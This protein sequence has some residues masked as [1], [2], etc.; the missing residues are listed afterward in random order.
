MTEHVLLSVINSAR[1]PSG[2]RADS[3]SRARARA[4]DPIPYPSGTQKP[5][6]VQVVPQAYMRHDRL[7]SK[8]LE[9]R[10]SASSEKPKRK[11]NTQ[12]RPGPPVFYL[13]DPEMYVDPSARRRVLRRS[14]LR[15]EHCGAEHE[16]RVWKDL[17]DRYTWW[18]VIP[19]V[20]APRRNLN[21]VDVRIVVV[22]ITVPWNGDDATLVALCRGCWIWRAVDA[23][24]PVPASAQPSLWGTP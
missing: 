17:Y 14:D 8:D 23:A 5:P 1:I 18:P 9:P 22:P 16:R 11:T 15:C 6:T 12:P 10:A 13:D 4:R 2:F 20:P 19:G 7:R 24:R 21:T 3:A